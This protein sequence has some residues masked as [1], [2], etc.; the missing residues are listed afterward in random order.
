MGI[1]KNVC[2]YTELHFDKCLCIFNYLLNKLFYE[3]AFQQSSTMIVMKK[4]MKCKECVSN[5]NLCHLHSD[6]IKTSIV[7]DAH[8][9][10]KDIETIQKKNLQNE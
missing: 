7:N 8:N 2:I 4:I 10:I 3:N 5:E 1:S 9:W 6:L